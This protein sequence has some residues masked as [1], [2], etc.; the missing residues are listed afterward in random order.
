MRQKRN[1]YEIHHIDPAA[2]RRLVAAYHQAAWNQRE[3]ARRLQVNQGDISRLICRGI[4]PTDRTTHGQEIRVKLFLPRLKPRPKVQ[5]PPR[6]P[7]L[8]KW[9]YKT[10]E[11]VQW[12]TKK[13]ETI[14]QMSRE[15]RQ[16]VKRRS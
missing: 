8:P 13:R 4:E 15:T 11:A 9:F 6:P 5:Q 14:K 3:L 10:E 2:P 16:S 1:F 7:R 12:F